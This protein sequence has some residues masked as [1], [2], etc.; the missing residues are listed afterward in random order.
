LGQ[1]VDGVRDL[2]GPIFFVNKEN[3]H[4]VLS[5]GAAPR[6]RLAASVIGCP[7]GESAIC[8]RTRRPSLGDRPALIASFGDLG[9]NRGYVVGWR[10]AGIVAL[11][12]RQIADPPDMIADPILVAVGPIQLATGDR[13]SQIDRLDH[14]AIAEATAADVVDFTAARR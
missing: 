11:E 1:I 13:L 10:P 7:L 14:R 4:R 3:A 5:S 12:A 6:V 8:N 9:Q 2:F